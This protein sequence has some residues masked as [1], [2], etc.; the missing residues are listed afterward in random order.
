MSE[1]AFTELVAEAAAAPVDGWG[2]SW[3]DGRATE[4]RPPWGYT[5]LVAA[6]M[7]E[8]SAALDIDTGGGEVLAEVP[9]PPKLLIATEAWPPNV[10]VA[11]QTLGTLGARVVQVGTAPPLPFRDGVFDLVTSRHPVET[12][13]AEIARVLRP[14]GRYLSQQIGAGTMR[15]LSEAI[16]GPLPPPA[17][18][19]PEQAVAAAHA[20]GLR[21]VRLEPATLRAVF[22]DIGAVVWFLRKVVW[23]VPGFDVERYRPELERLHARIRADGPFVAHARRFLIEAVEPG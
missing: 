15:E 14:D 22:H 6:R 17:H 13:W 18:R 4:E 11:R 2:F 3:L 20:A 21:V 12:W 9:H 7:A 10:A 16:L 23:T 1:R 19:H 8:A 5:R